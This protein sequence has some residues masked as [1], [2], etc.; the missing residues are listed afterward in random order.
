[1]RTFEPPDQKI[2]QA[3][4]ADATPRLFRFLH[5]AAH[6]PNPE[7]LDELARSLTGLQRLV[8]E[9]SLSL[10]NSPQ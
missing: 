9:L 3:Q 5:L 1:M 6:H 10:A 2:I 7:Q 4:I 8:S